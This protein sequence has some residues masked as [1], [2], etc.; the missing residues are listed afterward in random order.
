M[1]KPKTIVQIGVPVFALMCDRFSS[2][3]SAI[4]H[5]KGHVLIFRPSPVLRIASYPVSE[6]VPAKIY[7]G[8]RNESLV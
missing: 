8:I 7:N 3:Q 6:L 4:Y 5:Y 2:T 1:Q